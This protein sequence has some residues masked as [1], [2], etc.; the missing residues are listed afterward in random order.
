[1]R[2]KQNVV[3]IWAR[4]NRNG[5]GHT[6]YLRY[7]D[8]NGKRRCDSLSHND[9]TKA[10]KA[11]IKKE[12]ELRMGYCAPESMRLKEF[13]TDS[14]LRTGDQIRQS[15]KE[16]YERIIEEFISVVGNLDY[17]KITLKHGE[18]YR[19][20]CLDKGNTPATVAK[21]LRHLKRLFQ[22]GANRKQLDENCLQHIDMPKKS[23]KK[24]IRIYSDDECRR[25]LKS[26][27]DYMLGKDD[28]ITVQWDILVM[29][30]L[31]TGMRRGELLNMCWSDIDFENHQIDITAKEDTEETWEWKIKDSDE[32]SVPLS[33]HT[34][35]LLAELQGKR[36]AGYP[37]VFVPVDRYD[38]IQQ[39]RRAKGK[40]N[41]VSSRLDVVN[42]FYRQWEEI[43]KRA[44]IRKKGTFHDL[45]RTALSRWLGKM[46][47]YELMTLAGHS[48]F[49]TTHNFYLALKKDHLDKARQANEVMGKMG[50]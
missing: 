33:E 44:G 16:E 8:L 7:V 48:S 34:T 30:A 45:R 38:F 11:R 9:Q 6:L 29:T 17:Q 24:K 49:Q 13:F 27:K 40:W 26:A 20:V 28:K 36:P 1:M 14:L 32:R 3:M 37:Y 21:K 43:Q 39:E 42:N 15:T 5:V 50:E 12:R 23:T 2:I 18:Y 35:K 19:Q 47:E 46:S 4:P 10:E 22:L 41:L 31:E 25:M